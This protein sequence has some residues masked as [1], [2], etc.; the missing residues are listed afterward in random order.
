M[1][2][3]NERRVDIADLLLLLAATLVIGA[4]A[5]QPYFFG[6]ELMPFYYSY[7]P[8]AT[9]WSI[10]S[11][12]NAYKPRLVF[13]GIWALGAYFAAPRYA[14][15]LITIGG[16]V[17]AAWLLY[18]LAR[19]Q[20]GASR[21]IA[22]SAGAVIVTSR[23]SM[24]VYY[25]YIAGIIEALSM[26]C[27]LFAVV[28]VIAPSAFKSL[29]STIRFALTV[30]ACVVAVFIHERYMAGTVALGIVV[31]ARSVASL[32]SNPR[33]GRVWHGIVIAV[34]PVVAF[35]IANKACGSLPIATGTA[36]K[37]VTL[38]LGTLERATVYLGNVFL[39]LNHGYQWLVGSLQLHGTLHIAVI[40][41]M[42]TVLALI[43][44]WIIVYRRKEIQWVRVAEIALLIC[45]LIAA[46]SLPG[47]SRQEGRWMTPVLALAVVMG[48]HLGRTKAVFLA[49]LLAANLIYLMAS[50][51]SSVYNIEAS[52]MADAIAA[53]LNT[54]HPSGRIGIV[55]NAASRGTHWVLG[56][57]GVSGNTGDS[58]AAFSRANFA[59]RVQVD[60]AV[61]AG[62]DYD[63]G[64]YY[65]G[66]PNASR[67]VFAY[68][69]KRQVQLIRHPETLPNGAGQLIG[70][71]DAWRQWTWSVSPRLSQEGVELR[72]GVI[73]TWS[74]P[75]TEL[76]HKLIVY[77]ARS[78][79]EGPV[80]MRIQV[81]WSGARGR[82]LGTFITVV[83]VGTTMENFV[84]FMD[85]PA[86]ATGGTIY[87]NLQDGATGAV[88]LKSIRLV[89]E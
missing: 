1:Q 81:N 68:L 78:L 46:A 38:S 71:S 60:P 69:D 15:M 55:L 88:E 63:F 2:I 6:D 48:M 42:A 26:A 25:D 9:L 85:A 62:G 4:I 67:P 14:F 58:G 36:A 64:L 30:I 57:A 77:R 34:I 47:W 83:G 23:F 51:E 61:A 41:V 20:F 86:G 32:R 24:L 5:Y 37:P 84:A 35:F 11:Q 75:S 70:G 54:L 21:W 65:T 16:I 80:P 74:M 28:L 13:N 19:L 7:E 3:S 29:G 59:S 52:R 27:F 89:D 50:S 44:I 18:Y 39:A 43:Y 8:G 72:P 76:D 87:A 31:I 82:Y 45:A 17:A 40:V 79:T 33:V 12:L 73:G 53:P 66:E 10:Y 56:G 49:A 22:L